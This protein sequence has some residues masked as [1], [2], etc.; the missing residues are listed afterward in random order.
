MR[1]G[2]NQIIYFRFFIY[3]GNEES[4]VFANIDS[5]FARCVG[6]TMDGGWRR[7][8]E[9]CFPGG[10][11]SPS[12]GFHQSQL[13]RQAPEA[14]LLGSFPAII[15]LDMASVNS[16]AISVVTQSANPRT[17]GPITPPDTVLPCRPTKVR[18]MVGLYA[19]PTLG[20]SGTEKSP[21]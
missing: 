12:A 3:Q 17:H 4:K 13:T 9:V 18:V 14:M 2:T 16:E 20:R 15:R 5:S 10:P 6:T 21:V 19:H 11:R 1:H 7:N 8:P